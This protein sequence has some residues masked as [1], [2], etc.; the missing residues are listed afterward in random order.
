METARPFA[1]ET[2]SRDRLWFGFR[3]DSR[4]DRG[5][6]PA[7][8]PARPSADQGR[9]PPDRLVGT[10]AAARVSCGEPITAFRTANSPTETFRIWPH[11]I[12]LRLLSPVRFPAKRGAE[13]RGFSEPTARR[14]SQGDW[15][16]EGPV[17]SEPVSGPNS[18]LTGKITGNF[19]KS[20]PIGAS[21]AGKILVTAMAYRQIPYAALTGNFQRHNRKKKEP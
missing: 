18:L 7:F 19:A 4:S 9:G 15:L 13:C 2:R 20:G 16:A 14:P 6:P 3:P 11:R 10:E 12:R 21:V 5:G 8:R 1:P 17:S